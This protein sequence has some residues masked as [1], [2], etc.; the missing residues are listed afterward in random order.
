MFIAVEIIN[1][2]V[3]GKEK[4]CS[5]EKLIFRFEWLCVRG[6]GKLT[7]TVRYMCADACSLPLSPSDGGQVS[8]QQH[9]LHRRRG[10][11]GVDRVLQAS[12]RR[13]PL[14]GGGMETFQDRQELSP[15]DVI[16]PRRV[17]WPRDTEK[18]GDWSERLGVNFNSVNYLPVSHF[19]SGVCDY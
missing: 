16:R 8:L 3:L 4:W 7:I 6:W 15:Q 2:Y 10:Q 19:S 13:R 9:A 14:S 18:D 12:R 11:P 1:E 5:Q 17:S